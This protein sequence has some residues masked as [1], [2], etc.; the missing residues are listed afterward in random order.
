MSTTIRD[1][2]VS[3]ERASHDIT[4]NRRGAR[5]REAVLD[6]AERLIAQH[7]YKAAT[8][9]ALVDE[10]GVAASSIYHY[11]DCKQGVVVATLE[12]GA[13][14]FFAELPLAEARV[15]PELDHLRTRLDAVA[16]TLERHPDF[17]RILVVRAAQPAGAGGG[18]IDRVVD[19]V[20]EL[21]LRRLRRE[22]HVAFGLDPGGVG[23]DRLAR[24]SLAALAGAV[25]ADRSDRPVTL[26][27]VLAHLP[28]ALVAV[29]RELAP[30]DHAAPGV[31]RT[32][33]PR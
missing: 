26:R 3:R 17:A 2:T 28:A 29:R 24:F 14:R 18:E 30:P 25:I 6:A 8:V 21:A 31:R 12:R 23:A 32:R 19:R 10:A 15:G 5:S 4:P 27:D 33:S 1:M 7:G 16:A 9:S 20:R 22:M 13:E 11:F